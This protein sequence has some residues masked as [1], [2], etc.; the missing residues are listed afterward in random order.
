[1]ILEYEQESGT[2][3]T[4]L[5]NIYKAPH[6]FLNSF[7]LQNHLLRYVLQCDVEWFSETCECL[8]T[9]PLNKFSF[10]DFVFQYFIILKLASYCKAEK[11]IINYL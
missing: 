1:M 9:G 2:E 10:I 4:L 8:D 7:F 5:W 11:S 6:I 3:V